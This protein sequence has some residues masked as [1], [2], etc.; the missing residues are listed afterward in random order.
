MWRAAARGAREGRGKAGGWSRRGGRTVGLGGGRVRV[1]RDKA[2]FRKHAA[3][4]WR[5]PG[6]RRRRTSRQR[7]WATGCATAYR[8]QT[9]SADVQQVRQ[10]LEKQLRRRAQEPGL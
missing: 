6:A 5:G 2:H 4:G 10:R 1:V 7:S 3:P 8:Q 9:E